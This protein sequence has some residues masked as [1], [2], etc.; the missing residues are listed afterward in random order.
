MS[1]SRA[2]F[3]ADL[4]RLSTALENTGAVRHEPD[5]FAWIDESRAPV[6]LVSAYRRLVIY[7]YANGLLPYPTNPAGPVTPADRRTP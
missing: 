4:D 6:R 7:G 3:D 1:A 2:V 5:G